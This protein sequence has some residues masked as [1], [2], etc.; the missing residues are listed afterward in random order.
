[1]SLP[2]ED[3]TNYYYKNVEIKELRYKKLVKLKKLR[4]I[5]QY[6]IKL[7]KLDIDSFSLMK[8]VHINTLFY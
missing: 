7:I 1:M 4:T 5:I 8:R 3:M 2:N 6:A